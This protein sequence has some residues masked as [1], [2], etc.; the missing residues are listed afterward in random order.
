MQ[1][2]AFRKENCVSEFSPPGRRGPAREHC[3][4]T[5]VAQRL[6]AAAPPLTTGAQSMKAAVMTLSAA[7]PSRS[8]AVQFLS[9]A[10]EPPCCAAEPPILAAR[11]MAPSVE[12]EGISKATATPAKTFSEA[13]EAS[14][15]LPRE[16]P[17]WPWIQR[18]QPWTSVS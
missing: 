7:A 9:Q 16:P 8:T 17:G 13:P 4:L 18:D 2:T 10:T 5:A 3:S 11:A 12:A 6:T 15:Q 14:Q 1:R